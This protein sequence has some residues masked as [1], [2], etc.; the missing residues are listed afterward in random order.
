MGKLPW[1]RAYITG[2]SSG[3]G[4]AIAK[5][6]LP[7]GIELLLIA[8]RRERL[9]SAAKELEELKKTDGPALHVLPLDIAKRESVERLLPEAIDRCGAPD[10]LINCA[11]TAYPN[12][13][14]QIPYD[15][16]R[17]TLEI[18]V[19][20]IWNVTQ[21]VLP[22]M[23]KGSRIVTVSS[24]A[25][26]VGT[27]GYTAYSA[28]KFA[29]IGFSESLCNELSLKGIGVSVLCPPDTRTAQLEEE[30][31]TKPPE[32]KAISAN[33][34]AL[35]A[36]EVAKVLL[37]G[38]RRGKFIIIPGFQ[39]KLVYYLHRFMPGLLRSILDGIVR[40]STGIDNSERERMRR[41]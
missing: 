39:G 20:G 14:E 13:F 32:T 8:R 12:Y 9:E 11:G 2:G 25:G 17:E 41:K 36:E 38:L 5:A 31:K 21:L 18:N 16:F 37:R 7:Y 15:R 1:K 33:A 6:L 34:P 19:A 29:V 10:L 3:I 35:E 28:S 23:K 24:I 40:Q 27:F 30:E 22:H 26:F 4:F